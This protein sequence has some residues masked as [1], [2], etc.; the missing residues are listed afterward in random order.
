M[1]AIIWPHNVSYNPKNHSVTFI[2]TKQGNEAMSLLDYYRELYPAKSWIEL[3]TLAVPELAR[4]K[5]I[6]NLKFYSA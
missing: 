6:R 3:V 1:A 5:N 2:T 4:I